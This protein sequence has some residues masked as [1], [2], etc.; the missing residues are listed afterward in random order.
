MAAAATEPEAGA[1]DGAVPVDNRT[2]TEPLVGASSA[3]VL[4][5]SDTLLPPQPPLPPPPPPAVNPATRRDSDVAPTTRVVTMVASV[6]LIVAL[7]VVVRQ[8]YW[9]EAPPIAY[10]ATFDVPQSTSRMRSVDVAFLYC[11]HHV[12]NESAQWLTAARR[13]N[14]ESK[15]LNAINREYRNHRCLDRP[16]WDAATFRDASF[17]RHPVVDLAPEAWA[18]RRRDG[19]VFLAATPAER[20]AVVERLN[21]RAQ[22]LFV[23][24]DGVLRYRVIL[25]RAALGGMPDS[26]GPMEYTEAMVSHRELVRTLE[27]WRAA[28]SPLMR[29]LKVAAVPCLCPGHLGIVGSGMH[30]LSENKDRHGNDI[31]FPRPDRKPATR[32]AEIW[33]V[34]LEMHVVQLPRNPVLAPLALAFVDTLHAFPAHVDHAI[35]KT[36][37]QRNLTY[38]ADDVWMAAWDPTPFLERSTVERYDEAIRYEWHELVRKDAQEAREDADE[39][40]DE[41]EDEADTGGY[42]RRK[43]VIVPLYATRAHTFTQGIST[44]SVKTCETHCVALDWALRGVGLSSLEHS[45]VVPTAAATTTVPDRVVRALSKAQERRQQRERDYGRGGAS[46]EADAMEDDAE[47]EERNDDGDVVDL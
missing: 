21:P 2:E 18:R 31:V 25:A 37:Q 39:G 23:D 26:T 47:A 34:L 24:A 22:T 1:A 10:G 27:T 29:T 36:A 11:V 16:R 42:T 7:L 20:H 12:R 4:P 19:L 15:F 6:L 30:F 5:E 40:D 17:A 43:S 14:R 3:P 44:E 35:L 32:P 45:A 41:D 38:V 46:K 28:V 13:A 9:Q 8:Q 33:R